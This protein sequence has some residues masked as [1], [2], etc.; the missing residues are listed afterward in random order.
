ME[1]LTYSQQVNSLV[2]PDVAE[3]RNK[4]RRNRRRAELQRA[5]RKANRRK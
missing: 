4:K 3:H 2:H 5:S 1:P